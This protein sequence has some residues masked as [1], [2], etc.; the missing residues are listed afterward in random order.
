MVT[1][2]AN[3]PDNF[4]HIV[5]DNGAYGSC[6]EEKSLSFFANFAKIAKDVGYRR[7]RIVRS[8]GKLKEAILYEGKGPV[9]IT[10]RRIPQ[11]FKAGDECDTTLSEAKTWY[12]VVYEKNYL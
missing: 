4:V 6:S 5:L 1:I 12:N 7:I 2:G 10:S 9:F 3:K 8:V 11:P